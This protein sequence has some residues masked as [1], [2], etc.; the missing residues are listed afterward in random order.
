MSDPPAGTYESMTERVMCPERTGL[1][2]VEA[3]E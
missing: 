2:E 1:G 3:E